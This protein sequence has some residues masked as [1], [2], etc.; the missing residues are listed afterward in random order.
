M[1]L[2]DEFAEEHLLVD[3]VA[4]SLI[5][6]AE[7]AARSEDEPRGR[8][9]FCTVSSGSTLA[10]ITTNGRSTF[11]SGSDRTAEVPADRG[12]MP[13][14]R[15]TT[16][17]QRRWSTSSRRRLK[18]PGSRRVARRLAHH[19]WEHV[20]KEDSVLFPESQQRR[21]GWSRGSRAARRPPRKRPR[22]N[23]VRSSPSVSA[24]RRPRGRPRR[25]LHRLLGVRRHLR[26]DREGVVER[27]GARVSPLAG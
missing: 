1:R 21:P 12:P 5:R 18:T 22:V 19:L 6:F 24:P 15:R 4:G 11:F 9:R 26:W 16:A 3:R 7:A 13:S 17:R 25:R 23:S 10:A 27:L 8:G 14:S 2:L 20:D